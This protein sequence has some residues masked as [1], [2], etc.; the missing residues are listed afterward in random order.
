MFANAS[1]PSGGFMGFWWH[2]NGD[3]YLQLEDDQLCYKIMVEDKAR[4]AVAWQAWHETFMDEIRG[5][6][7]R[8]TRPRRR[9]NGTWMT[10][11]VLDGDYR[12]AD[13]NGVLDL[14]RTIAVLKKAEGLLDA[15]AAKAR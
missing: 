12:R 15:A 1:N 4:Q 7:L 14:D 5:A 2:W 6:D 9:Q 10:V 11:A 3:K 8:I 13:E